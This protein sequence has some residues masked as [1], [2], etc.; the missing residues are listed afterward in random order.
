MFPQKTFKLN[1]RCTLLFFYTPPWNIKIVM[2]CNLR[3]WPEKHVKFDITVIIWKSF[4]VQ[5][6]AKKFTLKI[7]R[8]IQTWLNDHW[9]P[10]NSNHLTTTALWGSQFEFYLILFISQVTFDRPLFCEG[11]C[12][13]KVWLCISKADQSAFSNLFLSLNGFN[14][15]NFLPPE[16]T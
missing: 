6:L 16:S 4:F 15:S 2:H 9:P 13:T 7:S 5:Q 8:N 1:K 14:N 12:C 10:P 11:G 3:F